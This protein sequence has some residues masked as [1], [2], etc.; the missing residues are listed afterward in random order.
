MK[1]IISAFIVSLLFIFNVGYC[2]ENIPEILEKT[3]EYS[4]IKLD[5]AL[6]KQKDIKKLYSSFPPWNYDSNG[7]YSKFKNESETKRIR[8]TTACLIQ[9]QFINSL[10]ITFRIAFFNNQNDAKLGYAD[11]R[12]YLPSSNCPNLFS[13]E[14]NEVLNISGNNFLIGNQV[15]QFNFIYKNIACCIDL[16]NNSEFTD[17]DFKIINRS[18]KILLNSIK[19]SGLN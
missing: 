14:T 7:L 9:I 8:N 3:F 10:V 18:I 12:G 6:F 16:F 1:K 17:E 4:K 13:D 15:G 11:K 5:P 2:S 19:Q